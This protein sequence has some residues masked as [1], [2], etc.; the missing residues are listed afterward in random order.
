M[1]K[2]NLYIITFDFLRLADH[3]DPVHKILINIFSNI[4]SLKFMIV[5]Y[6]KYPRRIYQ[7]FIT[8]KDTTRQSIPTIAFDKLR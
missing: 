7:Y 3:Y 4:F 2:K 5:T 1:K 6:L 8:I